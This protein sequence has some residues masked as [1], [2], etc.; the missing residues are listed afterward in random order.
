MNGLSVRAACSYPQGFRLRAAFDVGPGVT[1]VTGPS[2]GGKSTLLAL[3]AGL[4]R[5]DT[6]VIRHRGRTFADRAAGAWVPP[7][8]RKVGVS[9]QDYRLFPHRSV[10]A[11]LFYG[12]RRFT[13]TAEAASP[14]TVIDRLELRGLLDRRPDDLS[15]GQRQRVALGR[16]LL[17]SADLFLLDEPV[18]ALD[19]ALRDAALGLVREVVAAT[20]AVCL[21]VTHDGATAAGLAPVGTITVRDGVANPA[22]PHVSPPPPGEG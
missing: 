18:S 12:R 10:E 16:A 5:P 6:G 3:I 11:N 1:V 8:R 7:H 13:P 2:G 4:I 19:N 15:G 9:F 17:T 21:F 20:G 14:D 22:I